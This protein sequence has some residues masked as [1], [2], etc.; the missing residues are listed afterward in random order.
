M[1]NLH[2]EGTRAILD[3]AK[4]PYEFASP[5]FLNLHLKDLATIESPIKT[6]RYEEEIVV[7]LD[8]AKTA[9]LTEYAGVI[10]QVEALLLRDDIYGM[11]QDPQ[12][13]SRRAKLRK[14][15]EYTFMNPLLAGR[16]LEE[17]KEELP[18]KSAFVPGYQKF[19]AWVNGILKRFT[20][21]KLYKLVE[22]TGDFRAAFLGM[23]GLKSL[24]FVPSLV[25]DIPE[26]AVAVKGHEAKY[27]LS[28]GIDVQI[29]EIP[30]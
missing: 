1:C 3:M 17:H 27:S 9:V 30:G 6:I 7:E 28:Y 14:F 19:R 8:E 2:L 22:K 11:K 21:T 15:Y 12:Y 13:D 25:L 29:Y 4:C 24:Y 10:R 26:G 5:E 18:E 16:E 23:I 20:E